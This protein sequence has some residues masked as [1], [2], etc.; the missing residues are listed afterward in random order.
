MTILHAHAYRPQRE[1]TLAYFSKRGT[2]FDAT[3]YEGRVEKCACGLWR[4]VPAAPG[5]RIVD[6][7]P[8]ER[9]AA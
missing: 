9:A 3:W 6:G 1:P 7:E 4:F 5:L 2:F 8:V